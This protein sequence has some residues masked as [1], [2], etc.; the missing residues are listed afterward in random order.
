MTRRLYHYVGPGEFSDRSRN[1]AGFRVT[2][3]QD[4]ARWIRDTQQSPKAAEITA[5]YVVD[6]DGWLR[7][8]DRRS[9]HVA[10]SGGGPVRSAG[11][12][13]FAKSFTGLSVTWVTNQ[14]VGFCPE[15]ESWPAV[16][17]AIVRAGIVPP[18]GFS[19]AF[20][21]RR[22][23]DCG[24]I[25]I[26]KD[27]FFVCDVCGAALPESWNLTANTKMVARPIAVRP[28]SSGLEHRK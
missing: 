8:A 9:E 1:V 11:E 21:F 16:R 19:Q 2:S 22:C 18:V 12:M 3:P 14:S 7:I 26:V 10:C 13:T 25:N 5:T 15:P 17:E 27:N 23:P 4:V 20:V 28:T 24:S 6:P